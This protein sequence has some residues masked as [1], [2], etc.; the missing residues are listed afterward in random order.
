GPRARP[1]RAGAT[2]K[3][4]RPAGRFTGA[5]MT[6]AAVPGKMRP[7]RGSI[8]MTIIRYSALIIKDEL[9]RAV[10]RH[11]CTRHLGRQPRL[12]RP[13]LASGVSQY[14]HPNVELITIPRTWKNHKVG[15]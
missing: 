10:A 4:D 8:R 1:E 9:A 11:Q 13:P 6:R 5:E 12:S 15:V 14:L 2:V 7:H 3:Y